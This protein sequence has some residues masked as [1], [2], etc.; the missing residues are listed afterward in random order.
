MGAKAVGIGR[1]ALWGLSTYGQDGVEKVISILRDE[2]VVGMRLLGCQNI[3]ALT[4]DMVTTPS[5]S[6]HGGPVPDDHLST[7]TYVPLAVAAKL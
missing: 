4:P 6:A 1:P 2:M 3:G 5:L 7:R